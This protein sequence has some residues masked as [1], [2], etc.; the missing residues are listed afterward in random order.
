MI[1]QIMIFP[2]NL[3]TSNINFETTKY[4]LERKGIRI[5]EKN[6]FRNF[7]EKRCVLTLGGPEAKTSHLFLWHVFVNFMEKE[8]C[9]KFCCALIRFQEVIKLQSFVFTISDAT[10]A[11]V[12]NISLLVFFAFFC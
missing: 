5:F 11:N 4:S 9:T 10:P 7:S 3:G 1:T 12:Q 6:C 2:L 8:H